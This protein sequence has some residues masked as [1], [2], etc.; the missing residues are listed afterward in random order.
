MRLVGEELRAQVARIGAEH[1]AEITA[2]LEPAERERLAG[3]L[4][5]MA[6]EQG[7]APGVHPGLGTL[8]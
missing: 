5:R 7:L 2:A 6:D 1:E 4:R 8:R 3:L